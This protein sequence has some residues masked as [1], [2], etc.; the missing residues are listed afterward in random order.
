MAAIGSIPVK[1]RVRLEAGIGQTFTDIGYADIDLPIP[2]TLAPITGAPGAS[3]IVDT[4]GIEGRLS[5]AFAAFEASLAL[6]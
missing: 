2:L 5:D 4:S 6:R 1:L 3:V